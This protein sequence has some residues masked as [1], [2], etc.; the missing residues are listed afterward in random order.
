MPCKMIERKIAGKIFDHL[1]SNNILCS[2]QHGFVTKRLPGL[3]S[4]SYPNRLNRVNLHSLE[5]R[6]LH[7]DLFYYYKMLFGLVDIQVTDFFE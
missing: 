5:L 7:M 3:D 4:L 1:Y 6:L 2:A